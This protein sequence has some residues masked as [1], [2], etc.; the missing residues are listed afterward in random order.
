MPS[1]VP[2][3]GSRSMDRPRNADLENNVQGSTV[4]SGSSA[5]R[6]GNCASAGG[7][8][9]SLGS[10]SGDPVPSVGVHATAAHAKA[11]SAAARAGNDPGTV[12]RAA[13]CLVGT[14][15]TKRRGDL[16]VVELV[17]L[18]RFPQ[19]LLQLTQL[20]EVLL[21]P[22]QIRLVPVDDHAVP[23]VRDGFAHRVLRWRA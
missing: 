11:A 15:F 2:A 8:A 17:P 13:R 23:G 7:P 6:P 22:R 18:G 21:D 14:S 19:L 20:G 10:D 12:K 4:S 16:V 1:A 9:P 5:G 3:R